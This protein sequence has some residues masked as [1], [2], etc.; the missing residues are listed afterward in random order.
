[1]KIEA[2]EKYSSLELDSDVEA[3]KNKHLVPAIKN[4]RENLTQYLLLHESDIANR[5]NDFEDLWPVFIYLLKRIPN[6]IS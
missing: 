4:W 6:K 5:I 3:F 2:N 1:M